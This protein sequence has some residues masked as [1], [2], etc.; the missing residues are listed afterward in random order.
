MIC[1]ILCLINLLIAVII[2]FQIAKN[3]ENAPFE[4]NELTQSAQ[5]VKLISNDETPRQFFVNK[6]IVV[7]AKHLKNTLEAG[8]KETMTAEI[9]LDIPATTLETVIKYLHYKIINERLEPE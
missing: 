6:D 4:V 2:I 5:L 1:D 8:V 7:Q 3:M 9:K